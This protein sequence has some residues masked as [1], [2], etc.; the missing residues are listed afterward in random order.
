MANDD[1]RDK[2]TIRPIERRPP[3]APRL[4]EGQDRVPARDRNP[5]LSAPVG[6][7]VLSVPPGADLEYRVRFGA[8][9]WTAWRAAKGLVRFPPAT[10][11]AEW[12]RKPPA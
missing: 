7:L 11:G 5:R 1:D 9:E 8:D 12:R 2:I 10:Q 3:P 6:Q 4:P